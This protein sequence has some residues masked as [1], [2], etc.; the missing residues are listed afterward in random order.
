MINIV[1]CEFNPFHNGHKY[2]IQEGARLTGAGATV[3]IMSGH[4]VQR[5]EAAVL[6]KYQRAQIAVHNGA[7]VVLQIPSAFTLGGAQVFARAAVEM[8]AALNT[9][10]S[11]VFGAEDP[12]LSPLYSLCGI[13]QS[14]VDTEL[15]AGLNNGLSYGRAL[16]EAY[17]KLDSDNAALL[18]KPNN[19]LAFEYMRAILK[20]GADIK[21]RAVKRRGA[22]H[23]GCVPANG[24]ASASFIRANLLDEDV[25]KFMPQRVIDQIDRQKADTVALFALKSVKREQL[26]G[27]AGV[28]EGLEHRIISAAKRAGDMPQFYKLAAT[29]RYPL[30]RLRR[31]VISLLVENKAGLHLTSVP[32]LRVLAFNDKGR[33]LLKD[34]KPRCQKP[35]VIKPGNTPADGLA[36]RHFRLEC[37]CTDIY[38]FLSKR[39]KASGREFLEGP[40]YI[41][42]GK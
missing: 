29:K 28:S 15:R 34:I 19:L 5:G 32:Y 10:A 1:I 9:P 30:S 20:I 39:P 35:V 3:C 13:C 7:D 24:F 42:E 40:F 31:I 12:D 37:R 8:A 6:D 14:A 4:F 17:N 33:A 36:G 25:K 16:F 27:I 41:R 21:P 26:K 18:L 22:A 23:D 38:D 11:L 2:L